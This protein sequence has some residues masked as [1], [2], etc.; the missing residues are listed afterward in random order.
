MFSNVNQNLWEEI[1]SFLGS[2][3]E[4]TLVAAS[5]SKLL[6]LFLCTL[7]QRNTA[8]RIFLQRNVVLST[9]SE[10]QLD[11]PWPGDVRGSSLRGKTW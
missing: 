2:G 9:V 11:V 10:G 6:L 3:N 1:R 4:P 5:I 8:H 7:C